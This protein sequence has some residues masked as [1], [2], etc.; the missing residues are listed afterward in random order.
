MRLKPGQILILGISLA[1]N[2]VIACDQNEG[3]LPSEQSR[4]EELKVVVKPALNVRIAPSATAQITHKAAFGSS[5]LI[6]EKTSRPLSALGL[7]GF[8]VKIKSGNVEGW[9]FQRFIAPKE[10]DF[11]FEIENGIAF[12]NSE[13][14]RNCRAFSNDDF[15]QSFS[16]GCI[17]KQCG[18]DCQSNSLFSNKTISYVQSCDGGTGSGFWK[19]GKNRITTDI[20]F[21]RLTAS[22]LCNYD[23]RPYEDCLKEKRNQNKQKCGQ[24]DVCPYSIKHTIILG[25]HGNVM[26]KEET[27]ASPGQFE[28][29][30]INHL[31][32]RKPRDWNVK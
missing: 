23:E 22:E 3:R 16:S 8:W 32:E 25:P 15:P 2:S 1:L 27:E 10:S 21:I 29:A 31:Q 6:L 11:W 20:T 19:K 7:S 30:C 18:N 12:Q 28:T 24:N 17:N 5:V 14:F 9:A 26:M 13:K 4:L